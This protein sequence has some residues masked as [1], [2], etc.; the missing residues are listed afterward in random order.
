MHVQ[1]KAVVTNVLSRDDAFGKIN[2]AIR[3]FDV[4]VWP[5]SEVFTRLEIAADRLPA[6]PKNVSAYRLRH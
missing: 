5:K 1:N 6:P 3:N 2:V 4:L